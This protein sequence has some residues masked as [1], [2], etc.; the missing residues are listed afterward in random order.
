MKF[1]GVPG[2]FDYAGLSEDSRYRPV[3]VAFRALQRRRRP[4]CVFSGLNTHPAY[5]LS[6]LRCVPLGSSARLEAEVDR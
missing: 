1:L 2:V 3:H 4:D 6:T 5:L